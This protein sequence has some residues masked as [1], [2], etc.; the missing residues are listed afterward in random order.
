MD[1]KIIFLNNSINQK[2]EDAIGYDAYVDKLNTA[3]NSGAKMIA[4]TSPF[5]SGKTTIIDLLSEKRAVNKNE[6]ILKIPMWSQLNCLTADDNNSIELH[7]NFLYQISS[8]I[9][10]LFRQIY[11]NGVREMFFRKIFVSATLLTPV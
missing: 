11:S 7:K 10:I 6:K 5:G 8:A 1:D 3:I 9:D 4:I 2:S